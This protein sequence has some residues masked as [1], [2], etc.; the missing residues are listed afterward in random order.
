MPT[1]NVSRVVNNPKFAQTFNVQRSQGGDWNDDGTWGDE[2]IEVSFYG[3][4][5]PA[6][7]KELN[8]LKEGDRVKEVKSFH[9][10]Q[11]MYLSHVIDNAS[12]TDIGYSAR[13]S[14]YAI[15]K[16]Q[17]Y[18]LA[19]R[20]EWSDFGYYKALGVRVEGD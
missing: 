19:K 14:D 12:V 4:I 7:A 16:N 8:Q 10:T 3:I 9:S 2:T 17:L 1:L 5:Q 20:Y 18:R 11:E 15:W 13:I 6:T